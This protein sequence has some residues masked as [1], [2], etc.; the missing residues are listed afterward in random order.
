[1]ENEYN[2][3]FLKKIYFHELKICLYLETIPKWN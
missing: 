3:I 1:M 2:L